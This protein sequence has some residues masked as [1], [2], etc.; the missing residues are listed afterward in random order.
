MTIHQWEHVKELL[1]RAMQL[2]AEQRARFLDE[3]CSSD[4][5]LRAELESLLLADKGVPSSFLQSAP[6]SDGRGVDPDRIDS[7]GALEAGQ[8]VAQ[9]RNQPNDKSGAVVAGQ[10]VSHYRIVENWAA[11]GWG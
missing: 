11:G 3:A 10:T 5:A 9:Q 8:M 7:A 6:P 1:H 4:A 2:D